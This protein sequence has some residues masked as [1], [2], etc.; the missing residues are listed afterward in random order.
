MILI[1]NR[2]KR[3]K[4]IVFGDLVMKAVA[5]HCFCHKL[6]KSGKPHLKIYTCLTNFAF[7]VSR[8]FARVSAVLARPRAKRTADASSPEKLPLANTPIQ[9]RV[10]ELRR[11]EVFRTQRAKLASKLHRE[12]AVSND[13]SLPLCFL[14]K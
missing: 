9:A 13:S 10:A 14:T 5:F 12:C 6:S 7:F 8:Q 4:V 11:L 2:G 1:Q 3:Y